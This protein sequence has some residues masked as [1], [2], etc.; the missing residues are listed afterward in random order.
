MLAFSQIMPTS[1]LAGGQSFRRVPRR[2]VSRT[3]ETRRSKNLFSDPEP[4]HRQKKELDRQ[5]IT[6]HNSPP[7]N[8]RCARRENSTRL[9]RSACRGGIRLGDRRKPDAAIYVG[10]DSHFGGNAL[11]VAATGD[12]VKPKRAK[13]FGAPGQR[14]IQL[15]PGGCVGR[16]SSVSEAD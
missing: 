15:C 11:R 12:P 6:V 13:L 5:C 8:V 3:A 1:V 9:R 2:P 14:S 16:L 10:R 7:S 4:P